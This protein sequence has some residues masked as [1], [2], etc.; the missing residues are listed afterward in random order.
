MSRIKRKV[1]DNLAGIIV[2]V[3]ILV[4]ILAMIGIISS[5]LA[6]PE[7]VVT[8]EEKPARSAVLYEIT[9]DDI[10]TI[11]NF[12]SDQVSVLGVRV[13]DSQ[14]SA[15]DTLGSPDNRRDYPSD[16]ITNLEYSTKIGL[17]QTG[18]II[19]VKNSR[20]ARISM[21]P[22]FNKHLQGKTRIIHN[23]TVIYNMFGAPDDLQFVQASPKSA[24]LYRLLSYKKYGMEITM[25]KNEE[26]GL[27]LVPLS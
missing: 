9:R 2:G 11:K 24:L 25:R 1:R 6:P 13:G 10:F 26:T 12:T 20:I 21:L 16:A 7:P 23:K 5:K 18:L 17:N 3:I 8:R 19:H 27:N 4:F 15:L 22:P 14:T